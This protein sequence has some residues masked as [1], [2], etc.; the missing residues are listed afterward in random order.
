MTFSKKFVVKNIEE[1]ILS[2]WDKESVCLSKKWDISWAWMPFSLWH[3]LH[4]WQAFSLV[5]QD[6][7]LRIRRQNGEKVSSRLQ[8][9]QAPFLQHKKFLSKK[10][11]SKTFLQDAYQYLSD[12]YLNFV[13]DIKRLW[14][15]FD[16]KKSHASFFESKQL[17]V[18]DLFIDLYKKSLVYKSK[19]LVYWNL[20]LQTLVGKDDVKFQIEKRKI[21]RIRYFVDT[22]KHCMTIATDRPDMIFADVALAVNPLDKRYRK[23][24]W[25][26]VIIPIINKSI[27]VISDDRID[28]TKD[29]WVMRI[30]PSHD[31]LS[32]DIA[33]DHNLPL[34]LYAMTFDGNFTWL[35]GVFSGKN[36][37]EFFDNIV[38]YLD[39]ISN[40]DTVYRGD[41]EVPYCKKTWVELQRI[42]MDQRFLKVSQK[43][44]DKLSDELAFG[45]I[46]ISPSIYNEKLESLLL[47]DLSLCISRHYKIGSYLPLAIDDGDSFVLS[48]QELLSS[49]KKYWDKKESF[50]FWLLLLNLFWDGRLPNIFSMDQVLDLLF[51]PSLEF[52]DKNTLQYYLELF[53]DN[54]V[55]SSSLKKELSVLIDLANDVDMSKFLLDKKKDF[56][57]AKLLDILDESFLCEKS[58][59]LYRFSL[60]KAFPDHN[61]SL[62]ELHFDSSFFVILW[63][64]IGV[65]ILDKTNFSILWEDNFLIFVQKMLFDMEYKNKPVFEKID[66]HK[67]VFEKRGKKMWLV[68]DELVFVSMILD[69]Y[70]ADALR[71]LLLS[72]VKSQDSFIPDL[73]NISANISSLKKIWNA[74]R[75]VFKE[76]FEVFSL[77]FENIEKDLIKHMDELEVFDYWMLDMIKDFCEERDDVSLA[78]LPNFIEKALFFVNYGFCW[79][80]LELYKLRK[81]EYSHIVLAYSLLFVLKILH[82]IIPL[83]TEQLR[84]ELWMKTVLSIEKL[85][86]DLNLPSKNYKIHLFLDIVKKFNELKNSH[87]EKHEVVDLY[88][89]ANPD[90]L[91]EISNY[92]DIV[93]MFLNAETIFYLKRHEEIPSDL[94]TE[95]VID[96]VLAVK[97][98]GFT[99]K[100]DQLVNL[101]EKLLEKR[102]YLQYIRTLIS[103]AAINGRRDIVLEKEQEMKQVK[104]DIDLLEFDV[105]KMK[106]GS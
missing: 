24:V 9:H 76:S 88:I 59:D 81:W 11:L 48:N 2:L 84:Q 36:M 60:K 99:K 45:N 38:Q 90:F 100:K 17:L 67:S 68:E 50:I 103:N 4:L 13:E 54:L 61:Y 64:Y 28:M 37:E 44:I 83:L 27:P 31:I 29:D 93:K 71:L 1:N 102:E 77:W 57:F 104:D 94:E 43:T 21:Y 3:K 72:Y 58:G 16:D 41:V 56:S 20:E 66:F 62:D 86:F 87:A 92:E 26:K 30:C 65:E 91:D 51:S 78:Q 106:T 79:W 46:S 42:S 5:I 85:S 74:S 15:F 23:F 69:Q 63:D 8:F 53:S 49:Y 105:S 12:D 73:S 98:H 18:R 25:K 47:D 82:P 52:P 89:Q 75:F 35:A 96:I 55:L 95:N 14:I 97:T 101:E 6:A 19:E 10:Q 39:D 33:K 80:Y 7:L 70:G 34:D 32:L 40:L 22:K